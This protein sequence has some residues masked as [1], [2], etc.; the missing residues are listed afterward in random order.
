MKNFSLKLVAL[1][2]ALLL[3]V[4]FYSPDNSITAVLSATI[5]ITGVPSDLTIVEPI[6]AEAGIPAQIEVRGPGPLVAQLKGR[7][8]SIPLAFP[9]G[10]PQGFSGVVDVESLQLP[11]G[12][13]VL[14][15][16]PMSVDVRTEKTA[17]KELLVVVEKQGTP[18]EGYLL[19]ELSV[20]PD[21]VVVKGPQ[22]QIEA[23]RAVETKPFGVEN[24]T[25][26]VKRAVSLRN[27]GPSVSLGV[28]MVTV[29]AKVRPV[30]KSRTFQNV[31]VR[32]LAPAGMA[33]TA[34]PSVASI[35]LRGPQKE[36]EALRVEG[37]QLTADARAFGIGEH[38]INLV[39]DLPKGVEL[40]RL[41]PTAALVRVVAKNG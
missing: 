25:E 13:E 27:Y 15:I 14:N 41:N 12:V 16:N 9:A 8:K 32:V 6:G 1:L 21:T 39:A 23:L 5:Q 19:E 3:K 28:T 35:E 29:T 40:K 22:S 36:V 11:A 10:S 34:E 26:S 2:L 17:S 33:V 18:A 7:I 38:S 4:Y 30:M 31:R 20:F 24:V 37:L